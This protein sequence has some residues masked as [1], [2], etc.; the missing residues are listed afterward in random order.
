LNLKT[1]R[2]KTTFIWY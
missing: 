2:N 1:W